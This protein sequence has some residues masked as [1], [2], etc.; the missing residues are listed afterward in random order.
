M[1][2]LNIFIHVDVSESFKIHCLN[3]LVCVKLVTASS[4]SFKMNRIHHGV[5]WRQ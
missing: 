1:V 5:H 3:L 4:L 2:C